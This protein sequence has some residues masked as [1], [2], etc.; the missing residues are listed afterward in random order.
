MNW[1]DFWGKFPKQFAKDE[2]IKQ[3]GKTV[4]GQPISKEQLDQLI[5]DLVKK[6]DLKDDDVVLDLCCGNGL[7][8]SAVAEKCQSIVGVDFS[9][10]L[11]EIARKYHNHINTKYLNMSV[12]DIT[13]EDLQMPK[14]FTKIY[15]YEGL[16]YFQ[17]PQLSH[18][19]QTLLA[20]SSER[21]IILFAG[22][23]DLGKIREFYDTPER[24]LEYETRKRQGTEVMGTWWEKSFI[25]Q[26]CGDYGLQC[27]FLSQHESSHTAHYRFDVRIKR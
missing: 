3:V 25:R 18:L 11:I 5:S 12:L 19:M 6:L 10:H 17:E 1:K 13:S 23:P 4:Q 27:D 14:T 16:Q 22:I 15:M 24:Q 21:V 9:K 26:V 8:T 20:L 2:F 7:I